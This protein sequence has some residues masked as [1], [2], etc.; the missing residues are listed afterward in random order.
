MSNEKLFTCVG[1]T[2]DPEGD[3]KVRFGNDQ[4]ARFK[5]FLKGGHTEINIEET[6]EPLSKIDALLWYQETH[7]P[8]GDAGYAV[9]GRISDLKKIAR[10]E[11]KQRGEVVV[12]QTAEELL[13]AIGSREKITA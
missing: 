9:A 10:R 5:I 1:T 8:T 13:R 7:K 2:R 11:R 6:P 4:V 3:V 12:I